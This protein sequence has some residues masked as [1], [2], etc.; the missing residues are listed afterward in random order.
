MKRTA[1][2]LIFT[3]A[4]FQLLS[5]QQTKMYV[6]RQGGE[7][8]IFSF[9]KLNY[10]YYHFTTNSELSDTLICTGDGYEACKIDRNIIKEFTEN[11]ISYKI[12]NKA[13]RVTARYIKKNKVSSGEIIFKAKRKNVIVNFDNANNLGEADFDIQ[14]L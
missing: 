12:F 9:G 8:N 11:A 10:N 4:L 1:I 3:V 5:A 2:I 14:I 7:K 13:I 6:S